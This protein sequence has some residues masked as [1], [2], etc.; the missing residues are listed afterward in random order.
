MSVKTAKKSQND[1]VFTEYKAKEF[2]KK[3]A[4]T[5]KNLLL[6][7]KE[8]KKLLISKKFTLNF[9]FPVVLKISSD[10]LIHKTDEGAVKTVYNEQDFFKTLVDFEKKITKF[11]A[12]GV[13]VE[14]FVSGQELIVGIKKDNTFGHVIGLGIGGIFTETIK[15]IS[16]RACPI[17]SDDFDSMLNDLKFKSLVLG[18][19]GKKNDIETLKK[20]VIEISKIPEKNPK[21]LE[22]DI[23]PLILNEKYCKLVDARIVFGP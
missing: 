10:F 17:N 6:D 4:E 23:N 9:N 21:I 15:D 8:V 16:F 14:E 22:L 13:I 5:P 1:L 12:R 18:T 2:L 11:K 20:L 19:R 7:Q 3:Y